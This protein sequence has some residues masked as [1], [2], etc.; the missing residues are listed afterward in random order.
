MSK[1]DDRKVADRRN[2]LKLAGLGTVVGGAALVTGKSPVEAADAAAD[3]K[4]GYRETDHVKTTYE[5]ARF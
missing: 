5:L 1:S 2:F 4:T 3:S